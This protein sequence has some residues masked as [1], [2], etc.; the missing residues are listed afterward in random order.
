VS[1]RHAGPL[2]AQGL[3]VRTDARSD[4]PLHEAIIRRAVEWGADLV[5]K[6]THHHSVLSQTILWNTVRRADP[7]AAHIRYF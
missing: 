3:D 1:I 5:V 2:L 6:D 4:Y 7:R